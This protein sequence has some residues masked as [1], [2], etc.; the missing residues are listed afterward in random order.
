MQ[1]ASG[2][3]N[4]KIADLPRLLEADQ[5]SL[6][7][8]ARPVAID[9]DWLLASHMRKEEVRRKV[10]GHVGHSPHLGAENVLEPPMQRCD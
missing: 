1:P 3:Q 8:R 5:T 7:T 6:E 10:C 9:P 4:H 2:A